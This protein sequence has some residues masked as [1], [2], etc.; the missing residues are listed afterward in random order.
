MSTP[1]P[2][3]HAAVATSRCRTISAWISTWDRAVSAGRWHVGHV[4]VTVRRIARPR[5]S[6]SGISRFRIAA[7]IS[8]AVVSGARIPGVPGGRGQL[9][10]PVGVHP[11]IV[12]ER[13]RTT[14][15]TPGTK[16]RGTRT[17]RALPFAVRTNGLAGAPRL[18]IVAP[19]DAAAH[20][21]KRGPLMNISALLVSGVGRSVDGRL[22][23]E[24]RHAFAR[25]VIVTVS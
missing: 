16:R 1:L 3:R 12:R 23:G 15:I 11:G 9:A 19:F 8:S 6:H 18:D 17:E 13:P 7:P 5:I 21:A 25:L 22:D 20:P 2:C 14:R 24:L 10:E 4:S